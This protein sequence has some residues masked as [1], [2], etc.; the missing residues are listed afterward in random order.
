MNVITALQAWDRAD[1]V[2]EMEWQRNANIITKILTAINTRA[3]PI[4]IVKVKSH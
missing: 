4:T 1:F 3:G 2:R